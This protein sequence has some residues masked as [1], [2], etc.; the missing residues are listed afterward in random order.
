GENVFLTGSPGTGKTFLLNKFIDYLKDKKIKVGIT[1]STGIASTH[2]SG[3]TIHSWAGIGIANNINDPYIKKFLKGKNPKWKEIRNTEVLIIDEISMLDSRRLS[4][5]DEVCRAIK[6]PF[7]PFG[8]LQTIVCGDFFQLPPINDRGG[9]KAEF[10]YSSSTWNQSKLKVCYLEKQ[11]RQKD[12]EF[13]DILHD[14]RSDKI[15]PS[16]IEKISTRL[17][18]DIKGFEKITKLY[19]HN[20]DVD[21]INDEELAKIEGEEKEYDMSYSGAPKA[22]DFLKKNCLAPETLKLKK[23]AIVMFVKN[24]I[25]DGYVNGTL[26]TVIDFDEN[27]YPLVRIASGKVVSVVRERWNIENGEEIVASIWQLPL[28]LAWAITIH[29]SQGMSLDAAEIDL[30]KSFNYGMGY[31]ALSRVRRLSSIKLMG[32]NENALKVNKEIVE[33]NKE[34]IILSKENEK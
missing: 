3:V 8:G 34:F 20:Q 16:T 12:L 23:G 19:S 32:I 29:K 9:D 28:R 10:A 33:K 30:S 15:N 22:V 6:D 5:V 17:N 24:K 31:V 7:L 27:E 4:L 21:R 26:G 2:I 13:S 1:A 11:Y 25:K 14:I 18:K